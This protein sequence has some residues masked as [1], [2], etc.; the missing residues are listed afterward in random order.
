MSR[1]RELKFPVTVSEIVNFVVTVNCKSRVVVVKG[2][3]G[4]IT[5]A[6]KHLRIEIVQ[7]KE[8]NATTKATVNYLDISTYMTTYKQSAIL[9]TVSSHIKNMF[10]GVTVGYRY[11]MHIVKKHFPIE[12]KI[13]QGSIEIG[14]FLGERIVKVVKLLEGVTCTKNDKN[15]EELYFDGNDIDKVSLTCAHVYQTC[16]VHG[17]D[18]RKFLDGIYVNEKTTV[19][20]Q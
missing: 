17:K 4:T 15:P 10:K 5:K 16:A 6:F 14:R 13:N 18:K 12:V 2:K 11:K 20:K 7:K 9:Y 1:P 8:V 3:R 19:E